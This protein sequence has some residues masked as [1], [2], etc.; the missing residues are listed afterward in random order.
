MKKRYLVITGWSEECALWLLCY[1][2]LTVFNANR[3]KV[4]LPYYSWSWVWHSMISPICP[5]GLLGWLTFS[6][7]E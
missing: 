4:D 6:F 2:I 7:G 5:V 3:T 1:T